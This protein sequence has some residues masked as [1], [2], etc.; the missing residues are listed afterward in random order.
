[1]N[2]NEALT[3]I[4]QRGG[5]NADELIAFAAE[6]NVGGRDTS[7]HKP[8][9]DWPGMS[10]FADEGKIIY[11]LVR[12]LRPAQVVEIG[13]DSGG[14]STHIL[15][16]LAANGKG[17]LFSVDIV[18]D[19]GH[20]VPEELRARWTVVQGDGLTVKL[21]RKP[22]FVLEDSDHQLESTKAILTRFKELNP[23]AIVSHD[24]YT[25]EVYGGFH[26]KEAFDA[27]FP[28]GFG[29]K[30]GAAFAGLGVWFNG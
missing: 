17:K 26:V 23:R 19:V 30:V 20:S 5:L 12:A 13:V 25:H 7:I 1:M 15:T 4:A 18:P 27:V 11:A 9:G 6:D 28:D 8:D 21:P 14:T 29:I 10:T 3:L 24:Y 22:D 16:A 2:L